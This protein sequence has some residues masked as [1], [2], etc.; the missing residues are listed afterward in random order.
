MTTSIQ[1]Q[2]TNYAERVRAS[3]ASQISME[4]LGAT[5]TEVVPGQVTI[6]MPWERHLTQKHGFLHASLLSTALDSACGYAG[7]SLMPADVDVLTIEFKS[8]C[9]RPHKV[10]RFGWPEQ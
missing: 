1:A 7:F 3:F 6:T 9:R 5:H 8:T 2:D 10:S 4:T